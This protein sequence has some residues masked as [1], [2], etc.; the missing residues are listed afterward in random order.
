MMFSEISG[1]VRRSP[2]AMLG[3][4]LMRPQIRRLQSRFDYRR[5]GGAPLLGVNGVVFVGHG[6][7][8][9]HAVEGALVTAAAAAESGMLDEM[10]RAFDREPVPSSGA[11]AAG[12]GGA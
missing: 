5:T 4:L 1:T 11:G 9:A 10:R 12:A 8:D 6:R 7:G 3:A 2:L